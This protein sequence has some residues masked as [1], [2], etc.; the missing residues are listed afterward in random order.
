MFEEQRKAFEARKKVYEA[1]LLE[2]ELEC[3]NSQKNKE[4]NILINNQKIDEILQEVNSLQIK[5]DGLSIDIQ[6]LITL[7]E[8]AFN[9]LEQAKTSAEE[10]AK[11]FYNQQFALIT[12]QLDHA[13]SEAAIKCQEDIEAYNNVYEDVMREAVSSMQDSLSEMGVAS[14][15]AALQLEILQ[16]AVKVAVEAAKREEEMKQKQDFYRL[17]IPESDLYEIQ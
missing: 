5:K 8:E 12:E 2:L 16:N 3:K 10:A 1:E 7:R 14:Q 17:V 13:V 6:H 9:A 4:Y 15:E 11:T